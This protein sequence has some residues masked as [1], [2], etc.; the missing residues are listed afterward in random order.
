MLSAMSIAVVWGWFGIGGAVAMLFLGLFAAGAG[1]ISRDEW[2]EGSRLSQI[3]G[4]TSASVLMLIAV[5]LALASIASFWGAFRDGREQI[6]IVRLHVDYGGNSTDYRVE[7]DSGRDL[8]AN[9]DL[10]RRLHEGDVVE[11]RIARPPLLP[12][13]LMSCAAP[14]P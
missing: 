13:R 4:S 10:Y 3:A 2:D 14:A 5:V 7:D 9:E 6:T 12:D 8:V 11:C 1:W